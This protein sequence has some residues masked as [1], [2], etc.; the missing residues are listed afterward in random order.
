MYICTHYTVVYTYNYICICTE[1]IRIDI[2]GSMYI[3]LYTIVC[4]YMYICV[5]M[6]VQKTH[7][8]ACSSKH[9][10]TQGDRYRPTCTPTYTSIHVHTHARTQINTRRKH[11]IP[12]PP[13]DKLRKLD[14]MH[15]KHCHLVTSLACAVR[16]R[17]RGTKRVCA[18]VCGKER[19][20]ARKRAMEGEQERNRSNERQSANTRE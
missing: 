13:R 3:C 19:E 4:M 2:Y 6:C 15:K 20:S 10:H 1:Y 8:H 17:E 14:L 16:K 12:R 7:R 9:T 5:R 18:W 11:R